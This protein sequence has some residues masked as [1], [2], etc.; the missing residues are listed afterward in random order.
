VEIHTFSGST[1]APAPQFFHSL[2]VLTHNSN[3]GAT[4]KNTK[5][6][7]RKKIEK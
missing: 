4:C 3:S 6:A 1:L 2:A 7:A 5:I